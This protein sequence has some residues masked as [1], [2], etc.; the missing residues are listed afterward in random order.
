MFG[1]KVWFTVVL[2]GALSSRARETKM[3]TN[4]M[5]YKDKDRLEFKF[6]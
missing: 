6:I 3:L 1:Q 4:Q 5:I 2:Y